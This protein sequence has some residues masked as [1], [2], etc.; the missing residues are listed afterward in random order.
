[1]PCSFIILCILSGFHQNLYQS[2]A[3]DKKRNKNRELKRMSTCMVSF[4]GRKG[5]KWRKLDIQI[6]GCEV[7]MIKILVAWVGEIYEPSDKDTLK[8][9]ASWP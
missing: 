7:I 3:R 6:T 5:R 1:M 9:T 8:M 2:L 4:R